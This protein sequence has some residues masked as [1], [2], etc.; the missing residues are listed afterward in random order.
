LRV[1]IVATTGTRLAATASCLVDPSGLIGWLGDA[2]EL[3]AESRL[4][5]L[6]ERGLKHGDERLRGDRAQLL[7]RAGDFGPAVAPV[8][9]LLNRFQT[10]STNR[11]T[12]APAIV[13]LWRRARSRAR[14]RD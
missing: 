10:P 5:L 2:F 8:A 6:G 14:S 7:D 11:S 13:W 3:G 12:K 9:G 1:P 4:D